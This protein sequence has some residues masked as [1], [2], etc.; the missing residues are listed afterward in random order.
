MEYDS[1]RY[2]NI[3][4][5]F[6]CLKIYRAATQIRE[7]II[8]FGFYFKKI[9]QS[10]AKPFFYM[11][12]VSE[13]NR[14]R[15]CGKIW[16]AITKI[17]LKPFLSTSINSSCH[18]HCSMLIRWLFRAYKIHCP[19]H[20]NYGTL[21]FL[22][23]TTVICNFLSAE[24]KTGSKKQICMKASFS[25]FLCSFYHERKPYVFNI[26]LKEIS[27]SPIRLALNSNLINDILH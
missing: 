17:F 26:L 2:I 4:V 8:L 9:T 15:T 18:N 24:R 13:N 22:L 14:R 16:N 7:K 10:Y 11:F 1:I 6:N 12:S 19:C 20:W 25:N 5:I 27:R 3:Y 21:Q 23:L